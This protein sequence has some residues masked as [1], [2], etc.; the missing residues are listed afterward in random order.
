MSKHLVG[1]NPAQ[2]EAVTHKDGP[3]LIIAG[4]GS[5][6]TRTVVHSIA[7]AIENLGVLPDRILAFSFT[8]KASEDLQDQVTKIVEEEKDYLINIST[9][10]RFCRWVLRE[11]IGKLRRDYTLDFKDLEEDEQVKADE[12]IVAQAINHLQYH[13]FIKPEDVLNFIIKCKA[14]DISPSEARNYTSHSDKSKVYAKI[15]EEYEHRLKTCGWIDY[16]NQQLFTDQLFREDAEVRTKWQSKFDLIFVDEY[17]DTDPVQYR[18]I[19]CLA[20]RHQNL[21]VVGDDDQGIYGFRGADIQNILNFERDYYPNFTEVKLEQNYRS[22][23]RIVA[24]SNAL[25]QFNPNRRGK[26]LFTRNFKGEKVKHLHCN[27]DEEEAL[28]ICNFINRAVQEGRNPSDFAVLYRTNKQAQVF[29]ETFANLEILCHNFNKPEE[30]FSER[31]TD[32]VS[33]MTIHK[34]KGLEYP[35]VFVVGVCQELLPHFYNQNEKNWDEEIRLLYVAITRA[36]NWLCLSSYE[37]QGHHSRGQSPFLTRGYIPSDLLKSIETLRGIPIPPAPEEM[38]VSEE[39]T[40]YVEPLPK[41]LL[42]SSVTVLGIDPGVKNVG[43]SITQKT[44]M[45]YTVCDNGTQSTSGWIET[46]Q[47]TRNKIH[48]LIASYSIDAIAV[49]QL[50]GAKEDWF[51]YVAGCVA[52]IQRVARLHKVEECYLYTPQQV[53]Y[54][55]T[56]KRYANKEQVKQGVKERCNLTTVPKTDHS[57][58]AIAVSLCYLRSYLNSSRFEGNKRKQE[59]YNMGRD[60]WDKGKYEAAVSEF[61]EAINIDPIYADAHCGLGRVYLGQGKLIEAK[62]SVKE[63]LRLKNNN[64]SDARKLSNAL[65]NYRLGLNF[66]NNRQWDKAIT[67]FQAAINLEPIFTDAHYKLSRAYLATDNLE[68]AKNAAEGALRLTDNYLHAR[69]LLEA[70][71]FYHVGLSF[72]DDWLYDEAIDKFKAAIDREPIFTGAHCKLGQTYLGRGDLI[73][74]KHS[75]NEALRLDPNCQLTHALLDDIKL[76]YYNRSREHLDN[77]RYDEAIDAFTETINKYPDFIDAHCGLAQAYLGQGDLIAAERAANKV[78]RLASDYQPTNAL[79]EDIG[80]AYYNRGIALLSNN[81]LIAAERAANEVRRLARG[82]QPTN[83]LL[84]DIGKAYYN[85]GITLLSNNDLIAAEHSANQALRLARGYQPINTL[86]NNI[87][88]AYFNRSRDLLDNRR[89]MRAIAAFTVTTNKY[90]NFIDAHCGLAQAYL[91]QGDLARAEKSAK[92]ALRLKPNYPSAL[93]LRE[94]VKQTHINRGNDYLRQGNLVAAEKSAKEALRLD[95]NCQLTHALLDDIKLAYYNRSREHL[96]NQRYDE[97]IDAFTETIN[98]YPDFIEAYCGLA[99]AYLGQGNLANAEKSAKEARRLKPNH[100]L[101]LELR[102]TLKQTHVNNAKDYL[103][104][105]NLAAAEKSAKEARRLDPNYKPA[106]DLLDDIIQEYYNRGIACSEVGEYSKAIDYLMKVDSL[107]PNNKE[108]YTCL[109]DVYCLMGDDANAANWYQKVT[110][111][112]P[113]DKIAY[114][115][116]GNAHYNMGKYEK[117]V[118]SFQKASELDP[119]CE[120]IYGYWKSADLKLQNDKKMKADRMISF[121]AGNFQ[122][123][124]NN[125]KFKDCENL[126]HTIYVDEF[127]IDIYLVTNAQYKLFV[128]KNPEWQKNCISSWYRRMDY[129]MDWNGNNYPYGKDNYPVTYV[130]WYAAMAYALWIGKRLPTEAEWEKAVRGYGDTKLVGNYLPDNAGDVWEWCLDEYNP[131][132]YG[133][134]PGPNPIVGA[135]NTDEIVNNFKN[136]TTRRVLRRIGGI[137]PR[138]NAPSFTDYHYGFRCVSSGTD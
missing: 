44:P 119:N 121:P 131:N 86:F 40:D 93:E 31:P 51:L 130:D 1:L 8:V 79:L 109:A 57:A 115:E 24:V 91:G 105:D 77:Q 49:E 48:E 16:E 108:V 80:K 13:R 78:R 60:Y 23:K 22:T 4:P 62:N 37:K 33:L 136:V 43:W 106:C 94:I 75:A 2:R 41:K 70:I 120:M 38:K 114:I 126:A 30:H 69:K 128:D 3:L 45:G 7:Y 35:N 50:E 61:K 52:E 54:A 28:T 29:E 26:E 102:D 68:A 98:K 100:P 137:N 113:N 17:Q 10:H 11:D 125:S 117:S 124:S 107:N 122:M 111:I 56:G 123:G 55:A 116:L 83:A 18:I 74:A 88:Q 20:E 92:K 15:Y 127:Y 63:S 135:N 129:L 14:R 133:C 87:E 66:L 59:R 95:P 84:E 96:D 76:A 27:N 138:G 110:D 21:R 39:S 58:D 34:S 104:Q 97:A 9:F 90:P 112:D 36:K 19:K 6:K 101:V 103:K 53:K 64:Y 85:R 73:A 134:F 12:K 5:G 25:A 65:E 46:L 47:R 132:S 71:S 81:D 99:Q 72:L 89:Y 82:Y 118:D 42:S 67:E 32:A